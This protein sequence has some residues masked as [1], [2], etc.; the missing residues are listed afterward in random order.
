MDN[1]ISIA[2]TLDELRARRE[3]ILAIAQRYGAYNVRVF[4]SVARHEALP[5]SDIDFLVQFQEGS[6]L[7]E[8]SA[9]WQDLQD[10][11]GYIVNILSEAGLKQRLK[12]SI[13]SDLIDL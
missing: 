1:Q 8:L 4:G 11:L 6:S 5:G 9:L 2:P 13:E 7:F 12:K 10:L 3:E